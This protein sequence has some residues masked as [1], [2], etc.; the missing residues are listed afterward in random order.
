MKKAHY[1][2]CTISA[3]VL[4]FLLFCMPVSLRA[5]EP[6]QNNKPN[7]WAFTAGQSPVYHIKTIRQRPNAKAVVTT[8]MNGTTACF[9]PEGLP[10]WTSAATGGFPFD[11]AAADI[12]GDGLDEVL[13]AS[14]NGSLYA[15]DH[16]GR[17][18]WV[19]ERRPP[20]YQVCVARDA[21]G[22]AIIFTGGVEQVLYALSP[23]G[24][25]LNSLKTEHC[26][27][28]LRVGNVLGDGRDCLAMAT[29]SSG[30]NGILKLFLLDPRDLSVKWQQANPIAS[31]PNAGKRFF[32]MLMSDLD[33]DGKDEVVMSGSWGENGMIYAF[34]DRGKLL[35]SKSDRKIPNIPYRMNLLRKVRLPGDEYILGHFGNVL[36]MYE[37]NGALRETITGPF[38][39]ADSCFDEELKTLFMGSEVSGGT[40]IYAYRLDHPGWK[41][42][43]KTQKASGRL[44]EIEHNLALLNRQ[45]GEFKAPAY[46]PAPRKPLVISQVDD[47]S[48]YQHVEFARSIT[49]SQ[50]VERSDELWCRERDRRMPYRNTADELVKI[51]VDKETS[52]ENTLIWSG[53]GNAVYFPLSTFERLIQAGPKH[54]K[55]FVFAEMEGID[56]QTQEIVEKILLPLAEMCREHGK[57]IFFRN[58]NIFWTGTCYLSFWNKVL[59]NDKFKDVFIPGLEETNCRTQELSLAGR[60]GL[61]QADCF[62]H[63]ACRTVTDNANFDRMFEWG[64][65]QIMTHHLRNLVSTAAMGADMF[66]CDIH[67]GKRSDAM[68]GQLVPFY[69][70]LEKGILQ[71]PFQDAL[72]SRSDFALVMKTPPSDVYLQHGMNGHRYSF[73]QDQ[74]PAMVFNRLDT[75]WGGST[76]PDFDFSAYAMNVKQRT[77]NFL[78]ELPYGLVPIIPA[79]AAS[80]KRFRRT[81]TTDG[82][83]FLADNGDKL[84]A[85]KLRPEVEEALKSAAARLPVTVA[86]QAHWSAVKL[87][88]KHIRLTLIDPGYLDPSERAVEILFQH[89][90]LVKC[91]DILSGETL[92]SGQDRLTVTVPA[93]IFRVIDLELE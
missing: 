35:F 17:A 38:S 42:A 14:G 88:E 18:L 48:R 47:P 41:E 70:M 65:Q 30:L 93:G 24:K 76:L 74:D 32:S 7:T 40:E 61:W 37:T 22:K 27:R 67:L 25:V 52:G 82:E 66:F 56:Q 87:D 11:M 46:Q 29:A 2:N 83:N 81:M 28:H 31:R 53:H 80:N 79:N 50:K 86:G 8:S 68:F 16:D 54:L 44:K 34:N 3:N 26:I 1:A 90:K 15:C 55:G 49:L 36:I 77:C 60:I 57:I 20:L 72:L 59:L 5:Q 75:Y 58:K 73:F 23:D 4:F 19:F 89:I 84:A 33:K 78:P 64:G 39:F 45:I 62:T 92:K 21:L 71:I 63:W 43:F 6:T 13:V 12:D 51:I 69:D 10:I 91:I 85:A 9:S